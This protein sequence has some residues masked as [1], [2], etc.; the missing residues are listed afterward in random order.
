MRWWIKKLLPHGC[1]MVDYNQMIQEMRWLQSFVFCFC[2]KVA[3]FSLL[4]ILITSRLNIF[5]HLSNPKR[6]WQVTCGMM[7]PENPFI[8]FFFF[9]FFFSFRIFS[10]CNCRPLGKE[11][12]KWKVEMEKEKWKGK[13]K[14]VPELTNAISPNLRLKWKF[15]EWRGG[16]WKG[17]FSWLTW[18]KGRRFWLMS[19]GRVKSWLMVKAQMP[20]EV[21]GDHPRGHTTS[22]TLGQGDASCEVRWVRIVAFVPLIL[23]ANIIF[24]PQLSSSL[25]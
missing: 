7:L 10:R 12:K 11:K 5:P 17:F 1:H 3:R 13:I 4:L 18:L 22:T 21:A 6:K 19:F 15:N 2:S 20:Y 25:P 8:F 24:C 16:K 14:N 23:R 9:F